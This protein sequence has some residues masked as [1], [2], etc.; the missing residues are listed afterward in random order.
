MK[1]LRSYWES[2]YKQT[3]YLE[4]HHGRVSYQ[5]DPI[6]EY[7][8][9]V[10]DYDIDGIDSDDLEVDETGCSYYTYEL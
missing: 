7:Q 2:W 9:K 1:P 3:I 10:R 5:G 4:V 8:F 6:P